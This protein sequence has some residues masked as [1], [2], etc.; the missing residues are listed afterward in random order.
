M[1]RAVFVI[2]NN[3]LT[4]YAVDESGFKDSSAEA[5]YKAL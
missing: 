2:D 3:V 5:V 1:K 4:H